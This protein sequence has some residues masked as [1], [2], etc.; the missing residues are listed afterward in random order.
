METPLG[1]QGAYT[2]SLLQNIIK[3]EK[4]IQYCCQVVQSQPKIDDILR[5][6]VKSPRNISPFDAMPCV[7]E[8]VLKV[9]VRYWYSEESVW[10]VSVRDKCGDVFVLLCLFVCL[11]PEISSDPG[12]G[13]TTLPVLS[14]IIQ[15]NPLKYMQF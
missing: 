8:D 5:N 1:E 11:Y 13:K 12:H 6:S 14:N 4:K 7:V 3:I 2:H 15:P 10:G 9:S